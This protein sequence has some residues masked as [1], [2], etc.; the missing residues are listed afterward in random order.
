[1]MEELVSNH[2]ELRQI[3]GA[4]ESDFPQW[5]KWKDLELLHSALRERILG[6]DGGEL[7]GWMPLYR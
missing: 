1:M 3:Y 4:E 5:L 7:G 6:K 2:M